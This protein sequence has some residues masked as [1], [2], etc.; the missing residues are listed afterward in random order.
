MKVKFQYADFSEWEDSPKDGESSPDKGVIRMVATTD[1]DR[2]I[3]FVYDD[4][5]YFYKKGKEWV[6]G[7]GTPKRE[8]MFYAGGKVESFERPVK[9]PKNSVLRKGQTVSQEDAVKFGLIK[10]VNEKELH[11][12]RD[13]P[14][15]KGCCG[16]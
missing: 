10:S 3:E 15:D 14:V 1:D 7:A 13:I 4:F 8:F 5:Y 6:F 2:R 12:K 11:P 16:D 9:I